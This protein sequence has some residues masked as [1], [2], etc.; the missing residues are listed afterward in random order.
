MRHA[1]NPK[2]VARASRN[3]EP[4]GITH[5]IASAERRVASITAKAPGDDEGTDWR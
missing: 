4:E 3:L 5:P 2:T 1:M